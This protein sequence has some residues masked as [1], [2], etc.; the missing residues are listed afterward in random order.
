M[1]NRLHALSGSPYEDSIGFSRAIRVGNVISVSGTAPI[2]PDGS[3]AH[4][5]DLYLQTK[6]CLF[7]IEKAISEI[8]ATLKDINRT[9]IFLKDVTQWELAANAHGEL[10]SDI[11]PASTFVEV[12]R[13]IREDW[14]VEIEAD[15]ILNT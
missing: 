4:P 9:R 1:M 8:G 6:T 11:K 10:F 13:F 5:G 12:S 7:I 14:L 2:N 3:T 15:C